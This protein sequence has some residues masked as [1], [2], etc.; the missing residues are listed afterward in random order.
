MKLA[1][2]I[3]IRNL[4]SRRSQ[5]MGS[6]IGWIAIFGIMLGVA[7][8]LVAVSILTGFEKTFTKAILG[9]NAHVVLMKEGEIQTSEKIDERLKASSSGNEIKSMTPFLYR[10]GLMAH[11]GRVKGV[12]LK[13]IDPLTFQGV[14]D[15]TLRIFSDSLK[16]KSFEK[17]FESNDA[18]LPPIVLGSDLADLL[19]VTAHDRTISILS[20][21]GDL[22]N[23]SDI[24]NFKKFEVVATF[25]SGLFE[26][27]SQFA[28]LDLKTS[29][30]FFH[31][32]NRVTGYEMRV[33]NLEK[34]H[35]IAQHLSN[36][37][38][39][40]FQAVSWDELNAEIF[41]ALK[42]E[43]KLFFIIMGLMVLVASANVLGMM[44]ISVSRQTREISI[45]KALGMSPR[46]LRSIFWIQ[47]L[48]LSWLGVLLGSFLGLCVSY[49]LSHYSLIHL[50]REVYLVSELPVFISFYNF[51][52]VFLFAV[53]LTGIVAAFSSHQLLKRKLEL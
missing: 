31:A 30:D 51:L 53:G 21:Q 23:V 36:E 14:Y 32:E 7:S 41:Q 6:A 24:R 18:N 28:L 47:G 9:F 8:Q 46:H 3:A 43:K 10:E 33:H 26:Y 4:F 42:L 49:Y 12:V 48:A 38:G 13:G 2:Q 40:P 50:A 29:Q 25:Q 37:F 39:I 35:L 11:H 52:I 45:L 20:P 34:A 1:F 17:W 22:K 15:V 5:S 27:D 44:V 16:N 19:G